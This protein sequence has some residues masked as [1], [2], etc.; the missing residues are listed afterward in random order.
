MF[1]ISVVTLVNERLGN[2]GDDVLQGKMGV[3]NISVLEGADSDTLT[4]GTGFNTFQFTAKDNSD[5]I[6][7]FD[8]AEDRIALF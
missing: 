2:S 4:G 3:E 1:T 7:D 8:T 6:T 5:V